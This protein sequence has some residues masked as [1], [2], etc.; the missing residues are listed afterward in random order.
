MSEPSPVSFI[1][2][3]HT[4]T[5]SQKKVLQRA[6][7]RKTTVNAYGIPLGNKIYLVPGYDRD[8]GK[9]LSEEEA[10]SFWKNKIPSLEKEGLIQ[11]IED[12][13][14]G[15]IEDHPANVIARENH[16][17]MDKQEVP[18]DAIGYREPTE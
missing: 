16:L 15:S 4:D 11:G 6:D 18:E 1:N 8:S 2:K 5:I 9:V 10:Y 7:G 12:N 3:Y 14:T 13:W 17:F